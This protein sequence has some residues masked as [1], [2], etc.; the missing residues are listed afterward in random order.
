MYSATMTGSPFFPAL[1]KS[2]DDFARSTHSR[3]HQRNPTALSSMPH[4]LLKTRS[5]FSLPGGDDI[6]S[7]PITIQKYKAR[8]DTYDETSLST[9]PMFAGLCAPPASLRCCCPTHAPV[10][11]WR[12]SSSWMVA[13]RVAPRLPAA[14]AD[15]CIQASLRHR[16]LGNGVVHDVAGAAPWA[17]DAVGERQSHVAHTPQREAAPAT[18]LDGQ[19][20]RFAPLKGSRRHAARSGLHG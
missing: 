5:P 11:P 13:P 14:H 12:S 7:I 4:P 9:G 3:D 19:H 6:P 1:Y 10:T 8:A 17:E 18:G 2:T 16:P 20:A 15:A